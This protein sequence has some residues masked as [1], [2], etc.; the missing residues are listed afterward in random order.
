MLFQKV[1]FTLAVALLAGSVILTSCSKKPKLDLSGVQM[2]PSAVNA[3]NNNGEGG[4]VPGDGGL[5]DGDVKGGL[6]G[7]GDDIVS[8]GDWGDT[9]KPV[10]G[11]AGSEFLKNGERWSSSTVYFAYDAAD[12]PSSE[13][14]KLDELAKYLLDNAGTGVIIEGHTD[15]RGSDEYNRALGERRALA[16]KGYLGLMGIAESRMQTISYGEDSPA[17]A[18]AASEADHAL[19]RRAEFIVGQQL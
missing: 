11:V 10:T 17:S 18:G 6:F 7:E 9:D 12:V 19:N 13:R 5:F 3:G 15:E 2:N 16:V 1:T 4:F 14:P 8:G